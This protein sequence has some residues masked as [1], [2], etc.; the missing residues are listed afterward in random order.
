VPNT[1]VYVSEDR[2]LVIEVELA[3]M[4]KQ[5]LE[6]TI[7]GDRLIIRGE[8]SDNGRRNRCKYLVKELN[9]GLFESV[10]ELRGKHVALPIVG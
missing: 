9:Y 5:D 6:L 7:E 10:L 1:D 2:H 8:R 3:A 4:K